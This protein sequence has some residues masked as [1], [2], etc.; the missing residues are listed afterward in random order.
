[1]SKLVLSL[2]S[3]TFIQDAGAFM[4]EKSHSVLMCSCFA[5]LS[6]W[7]GLDAVV[8]KRFE[9]LAGRIAILE[10]EVCFHSAPTASLSVTIAGS[11]QGRSRLNQ[12]NI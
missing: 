4:R 2:R 10:L 11:H 3:L 12:V 7:S 9:A 6:S 1:M 8:N 5:C